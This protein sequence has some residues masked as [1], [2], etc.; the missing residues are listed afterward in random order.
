MLTFVMLTQLD[1]QGADS[2]GD[3]EALEKRAMEH[4]RRDCP[5]VEWVQN[6]ATLGPYDYVD[7]FRAPDMESAL[8]VAACIRSYGHAHAEIWG[9]TEWSRFKELSRSVAH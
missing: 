5:D 7:I 2:P 6:L 3:F 9:A 8:K 4:I 1:H